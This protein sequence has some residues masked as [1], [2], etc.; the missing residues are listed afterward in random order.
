MSRESA[1]I[2]ACSAK[3]TAPEEGERDRILGVITRRMVTLQLI[4][5]RW[6]S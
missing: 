4:D 2:L 5:L 3:K 6:D 1:A